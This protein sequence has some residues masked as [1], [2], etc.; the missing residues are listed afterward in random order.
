MTNETR[1]SDAQRSRIPAKTDVLMAE[2]KV[3]REN[4]LQTCKGL[5]V[6]PDMFYWLQQQPKI[7]RISQEMLHSFLEF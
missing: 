7:C 6:I 3:G 1:R 4:Y 5:G 2:G